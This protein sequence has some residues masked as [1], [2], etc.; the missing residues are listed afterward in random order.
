MSAF[1]DFIELCRSRVDEPL[2]EHE[3][4]LSRI[5][6][7]LPQASRSAISQ[8]Y[9][10]LLDSLDSQL[11]WEACSLIAGAR[12]GDD[13]FLYF[14]NWVLWQGKGFFEAVFESPDSLATLE[15]DLGSPFIESLSQIW[16]EV[17]P[18]D[19]VDDTFSPKWDWKNSSPSSISE[20]LPKLW[21]SYGQDFQWDSPPPKSSDEV[22]IHELGVLR[23]G[24][25][26]LHKHGYGVGRIKDFPVAGRSIA[27]IQFE[28]AQ[29]TMDIDSFGFERA[30]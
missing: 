26:V 13:S 15:R 30:N 22:E 21:Q 12:C 6:R 25:K 3:E 29:R 17:A 28:D 11:Q 27:I 16:D 9:K 24:D 4:A 8:E 19:S 5:W 7:G 2:D 18:A 1:W 23:V 10:R 20:H 14:R